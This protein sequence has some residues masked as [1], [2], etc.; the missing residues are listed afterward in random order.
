M[1]ES[2]KIWRALEQELGAGID[3]VQGGNLILAAEGIYLYLVPG[4]RSR[5]ATV[6]SVVSSLAA[7]ARSIRPAVLCLQL[8][9]AAKG[10][11]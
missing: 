8:D 1:V 9:S 4:S 2:S 5:Q 3:W 10:F 11:V 6:K 7:L